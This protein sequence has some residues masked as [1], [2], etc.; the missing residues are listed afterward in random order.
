MI[1]VTRG[2]L[3]AENVLRNSLAGMAYNHPSYTLLKTINEHW[4]MIDMTR[5][6]KKPTQNV[7]VG[8]TPATFVDVR[9]SEDDADGIM[10]EFGAMDDAFDAM[11][12]L[13]DA[14][15][16]VTFTYNPQNGT[17]IATIT[18]RDEKSVNFNRALS[19]FSDTWMDALRAV[20]YKH[21]VL[22]KEDWTSAAS[23][24]KRT[25]KFG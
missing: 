7:S 10:T 2:C 14:S 22:L 15:Y 13:L 25:S 20:L 19:G 6:G 21:Y 8:Y 16:K 11:A 4:S 1:L 3:H 23:S 9:V 18:C 5:N 24:G 17:A 12:A